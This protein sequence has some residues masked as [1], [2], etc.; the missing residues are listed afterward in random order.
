MLGVNQSERE[1]KVS[2]QRSIRDFFLSDRRWTRTQLET[3]LPEVAT[4]VCENN[5]TSDMNGDAAKTRPVVNPG[6]L[7]EL[8]LE[9]RSKVNENSVQLTS[10]SENLRMLEEKVDR[11]VKKLEVDVQEIRDKWG[12]ADRKVED[13]E[14]S[15]KFQTE[16]IE[17]LKKLEGNSEIVK[18]LKNLIHQK[19]EL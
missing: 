16:E 9:I 1:K 13:M 2:A 14:A 17:E 18:N 8:L 11:K 3:V 19:K 15:L 5:H 4:T 6:E 12:K 7:R 10:L